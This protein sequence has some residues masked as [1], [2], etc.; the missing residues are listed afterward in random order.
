MTATMSD[1]DSSLHVVVSLEELADR[2]ARPGSVTGLW[3][4]KSS[5]FCDLGD[6]NQ[7]APTDKYNS[8]S[9]LTKQKK[10]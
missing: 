1:S 5:C 4:R 9:R 3:V 7:K 2:N 6:D 8:Q 10:I